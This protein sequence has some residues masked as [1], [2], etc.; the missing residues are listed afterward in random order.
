MSELTKTS[1]KLNLNL[2]RKQFFLKNKNKFWSI[3]MLS[4]FFF[5]LSQG[6]TAD[7]KIGQPAPN[8]T[9]QTHE[10]KSFELASQKGHYTVLFFYPKAGTPGCT[11]QVCAFRDNIKKIKDLGAEVYGISADNVEDQM[12][13][14]K[15]HNLLFTLLADPD[16]KIIEAYGS[17]MPLLKL[18]KRWTFILDENLVIRAIEKDVDPSLDAQKVA[19]LITQ[20]KAKK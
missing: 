12:N 20:L 4:V 19:D 2:N 5:K 15:K 17:K 1:Q 8:F 11:N 3:L 13:F 9:T 10:G 16:D 7:L 14:H 18:S 6:Q